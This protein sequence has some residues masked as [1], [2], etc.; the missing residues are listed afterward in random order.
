MLR[1]HLVPEVI[2]GEKARERIS[3]SLRNIG[4]EKP[5]IVSDKGLEEAGWLDNIT[6][7]LESDG[8]NSYEIFTG[9]DVNPTEDNI[10]K[11]T[12]VFKKKR[13]DGLIALG[14]GSSIDCAKCIGILTTN[15]GEIS[16]YTGVDKIKQAIP[17]LICL[18]TTAGSAA[19][20]S[21]FAIVRDKNKGVKYAII[22]KMLLSDLSLVDPEFLVTL[23]NEN[24][25]LTAIDAMSHSIEAILSTGSS[26]LTDLYAM[27]SI[28]IIKKEL[29]I[30][31][32]DPKYSNARIQ[33][34]LASMLAGFAFSNASLGIIH[35]I[36]HSLGGHSNLNHG[37][38]NASLLIPCLKF[39]YE[40]SLNF[41]KLAES[42]GADN[43]K[44]SIINSIEK[45]LEK[46]GFKKKSLAHFNIEKDLSKIALIA[47]EDPCILTNP[48]K[49]TKNDIKSIIR[50]SFN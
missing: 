8:I 37:F 48:R 11:G 33:L 9:V 35:A 34:H 43:D 20:V 12:D 27:R 31:L 49:P 25:L 47:L 39:N 7:I 14:G 38:L 44:E 6:N 17:P 10:K 2:Y 26:Q 13:C 4:F 29:P 15:Q 21:Q 24:I 30:Y 45:L 1:K 5:L 50:E 3:Q 46:T 22:S 19:D 23:D 16:E 40:D 28:A 42:L 41:S 32:K 18:P 36:S